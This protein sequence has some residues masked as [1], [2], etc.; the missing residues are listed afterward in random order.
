MF[1]LL[2]KSFLLGLGVLS[3]TKKNAE[4]FVDEA[5][6]QCKLTP[7]EGTSFLK[8]FEDEGQKARQELEDK[9]IEIIKTHGESLFP[10]KKTVED[11]EKKVAELEAKLNATKDK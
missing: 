1:D 8:T 2:E 9:V 7:E 10:N 6:K 11:L 5:I 3:V 4:A